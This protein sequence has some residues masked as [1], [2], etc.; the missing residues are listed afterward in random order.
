MDGWL[1]LWTPEG[2]SAGEFNSGSFLTLVAWKP[3]GTQLITGC[4]DGTIQIWMSDGTPTHV[5]KGHEN[6]ATDVKWSGD[7]KRIA[8]AGRDST[9]RLWSEDGSPRAILLGHAGSVTSVD[10][11]PHSRQL[12]SKGADATI[13]LW[14]TE[15]CRPLW[16]LVVLPDKQS[17]TFGPEGRMLDGDPAVFEREFRYIVEQ[18]SGAMEI[19]SPKDFQIRTQQRAI[20]RNKQRTVHK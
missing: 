16:I 18:P 20:S 13:R 5:L 9:I 8:S 2:D 4:D 10:W 6:R 14:D 15:A 1:R 7:E 17:I 3:D 19:V 11:R 12:L